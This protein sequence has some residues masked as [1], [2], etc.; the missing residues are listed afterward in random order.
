MNRFL[1]TNP[2]YNITYIL[3]RVLQLKPLSC[4]AQILRDFLEF[5]LRKEMFSDYFKGWMFVDCYNLQTRNNMD[6]DSTTA[7]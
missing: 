2:K 6:K 4:R 3:P 1:F 5:I 7:E